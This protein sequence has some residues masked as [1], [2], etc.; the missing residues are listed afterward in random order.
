MRS[1]GLTSSDNMR[2]ASAA[3]KA[4]GERGSQMRKRVG[5]SRESDGNVEDA[6]GDKG[7]MGGGGQANAKDLR[8]P[9]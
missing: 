4:A 8:L 5:N 7:W 2:C 9:G 1:A 3:L 6:P